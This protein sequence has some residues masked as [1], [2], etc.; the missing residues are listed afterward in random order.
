[1]TY[2]ERLSELR[3]LSLEKRRLR[4]ILICIPA[5]SEGKEDKT[6]LLGAGNNQCSKFYLNIRLYS[7]GGHSLK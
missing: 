7:N 6:G 3:L 5:R 4:Q 2:K 1:M